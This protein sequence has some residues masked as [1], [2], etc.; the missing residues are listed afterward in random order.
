LPPAGQKRIDGTYDPLI[1]GLLN[2]LP[3]PDGP[4]SMEARKKWLQAALTIFDVM[5]VTPD[6]EKAIV[7]E[8]KQEGK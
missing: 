6:G 4:W 2:R 7:I 1:E 3:P 8:F 5:Y